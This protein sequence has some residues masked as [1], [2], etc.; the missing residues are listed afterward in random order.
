MPPRKPT[1]KV[2]VDKEEQSRTN[3]AANLQTLLDKISPDQEEVRDEQEAALVFME[4][5]MPK[6]IKYRRANK[7]PDLLTKEDITQ[8]AGEHTDILEVLNAT[9]KKVT[10]GTRRSLVFDQLAFIYNVKL[11]AAMKSK[12][13]E[14]RNGKKC[15]AC[16]KMTASMRNVQLR[17]GDEGTG[18][19][20]QCTNPKCKAVRKIDSG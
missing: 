10:H 18:R 3:R 2:T 12:E 11:I 19:V 17:A 5:I 1:Q 6:D 14:I 15:R 20:L 13:L 7:L 9:N 4:L 8:I 16:G